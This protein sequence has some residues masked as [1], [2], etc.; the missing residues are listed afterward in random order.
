MTAKYWL[1]GL[2][3]AAFGIAAAQNPQKSANVPPFYDPASLWVDS[4]MQSLSPQERIAQLF[5][6]AAYS[7]RDAAHEREINRLIREYG[8]GGVI[9]FQGGPDR[10]ARQCNQYQAASRV[11]LLVSM[12]AEWGIGMR[13]DSTINYPYQMSLGAIQDDRLIYEMGDEI[14]RQFRRLGMQVNFAPVVDVNNNAANP[15][16]NYR[17]FGEDKQLVTRK[18]L[19]YMKGLQD[20]QILTS[21]KHF[22]GHGDTDVDS[23]KDLPQ[24]PHGLD[25]LQNLELYPFGQLMQ[26]GLSGVMVAHL[27]IPALDNTPNQPSTLS[28]PIVHGLLQ[29][30]MG[31]RG[32]I[33]TDALNM[34]GVAKYYETGRV[35]V[36]ALK[37]G[38]DALV[39]PQ[40]V[41]KAIAAIQVA[42]R[43]GELNQLEIDR[44]CRKL[45]MAKY[46]SGL[47]DYQPIQ[48]RNLYRDLHPKEAHML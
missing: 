44:K 7:N 35:E 38:N 47:A 24:I 11:P 5:Q 25:R 26:Q 39:F 14:A 20:G 21:A 33:F 27:N 41:P 23:H 36:E 2:F 28:R 9:F 31:F 13:L 32:I 29:E 43:S 12:D 18:G 16:I 10:Q 19:A 8:I 40:D 37:A 3:L 42:V 22:P 6:V 15:V 17:A 48:R 45:L 30:Q 46:W 34:Q 1:F 4:V